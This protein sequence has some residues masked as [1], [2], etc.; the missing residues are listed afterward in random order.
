MFLACFFPLG[1]IMGIGI[2]ILYYQMYFT[3]ELSFPTLILGMPSFSLPQLGID[4]PNL[5]AMSIGASLCAATV[6][7]VITT[8][9][10]CQKGCFKIAVKLGCCKPDFKVPGISDIMEKQF[11]TVI[12]GYEVF[13]FQCSKIAC[14]IP[15]TF[16]NMYA[17]VWC[18]C[19]RGKCQWPYCG[20]ATFVPR[21]GVWEIEVEEET[22][23]E[24]YV[25]VEELAKRKVDSTADKAENLK[26]QVKAWN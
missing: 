20:A 15:W 6:I 17:F 26:N 4:I 25:S 19:F 9:C 10:K 11:G 7:R 12:V 13:R 5:A 21:G 2:I 8:F 1:C 3:A 14:G 24:K 22:W 23:K 18:C 16:W